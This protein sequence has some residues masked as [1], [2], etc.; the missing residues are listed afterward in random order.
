M[1]TASF[2][3]TDIFLYG[4]LFLAWALIMYFLNMNYAYF[5]K[6]FPSVSFEQQSPQAIQ[7]KLIDAIIN[8]RIAMAAEKNREKQCRIA[9]SL[10]ATYFQVFATS[11]NALYRDSAATFCLQA[12]QLDSTVG[13]V[14]YLLGEISLSKNN[15]AN[16]VSFYEKES[17]EFA[18]HQLSKPSQGLY[19]SNDPTIRMAALYSNLRLAFLYSTSFVDSQKAQAK[20]NA[21]L[22][23]ETD[24]QRKQASIQQI[25]KYW[26]TQPK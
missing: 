25:G 9:A 18:L 21:Y 26:K 16:A 12:L 10:G 17:S 4:T 2:V 3:K 8:S 7:K 22:A 23:L 15:E 5:G 6:E 11:N 14:H 20:F 24:A 1:K 19:N 13:I